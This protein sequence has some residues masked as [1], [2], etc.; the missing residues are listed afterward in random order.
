MPKPAV[1]VL[2]L[3]VVAVAAHGQTTARSPS[4]GSSELANMPSEAEIGELLSKASEY[5]ET[6]KRTF[7][8]AKGSLEKASQLGF[9]DRSATPCA[10]ASQA[11]SAIK[12][13]GSTAVALVSLIADLDDMSLNGARAPASTLVLA[14]GED[15][16]AMQDFQDLAWGFRGMPISIPN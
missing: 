8:A 5:I 9:Y 1:G 12:K 2:A 4:A 3:L 15:K 11:I 16:R 10:Q 14:V 7:A 13:N 6:Y